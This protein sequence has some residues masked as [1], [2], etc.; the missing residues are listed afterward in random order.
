M[1]SLTSLLVLTTLFVQ[2]SHIVPKTAYLKLIDVW[3]LVL[4]LLDFTVISN[5]VVIEN[6]RLW[7]D[8]KSFFNSDKSES[9][10]IDVLPTNESEDK[11]RYYY[12]RWHNGFCMIGIPSL[13]VTF[14]CIVS[15]LAQ[16]KYGVF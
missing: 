3:Y 5:L 16:K 1:V 11:T 2:T 4:I 8:K 13:Y 12:A 6:L 7:V 10:T 15:F 14:L 9:N